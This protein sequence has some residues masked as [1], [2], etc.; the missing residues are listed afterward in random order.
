VVIGRGINGLEKRFR[1]NEAFATAIAMLRESL[2]KNKAPIL[3]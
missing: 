2:T 3:I 1:E